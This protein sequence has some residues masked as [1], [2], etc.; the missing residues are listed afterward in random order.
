M[1]AVER[2]P[3][4]VKILRKQRLN[5]IEGDFNEVLLNW[6]VSPKLDIIMADFCCGITKT[7]QDFVYSCIFS[8][9]IKFEFKKQSCVILNLQRGRDPLG[10]NLAALNKFDKLPIHEKHR[11]A[12][13]L[14][15][16]FLS[17]SRVFRFKSIEQ[18]IKFNSLLL[19]YLCFEFSTYKNIEKRTVMDSIAFNVF[20]KCNI[21]KV[22]TGKSIQIQ[23]NIRVRQKIAAAKAIRTMRIS[24]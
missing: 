15:Y 7:V 22:I 20:N 23:K 14:R 24:A 5:V 16:Y 12:A 17:I 21:E 9:G 4:I 13:F 19:R 8:D 18:E 11:G 2:D 1:F 10:K 3:Y 6:G